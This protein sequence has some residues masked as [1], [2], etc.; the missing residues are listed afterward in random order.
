[1]ILGLSGD[2]QKDKH[3]GQFG[4]LVVTATAIVSA[5]IKNDDWHDVAIFVN[6]KNT[7]EN[8]ACSSFSTKLK[9]AYDLEYGENSLVGLRSH[10]PSP[11]RV[12]QMLPGEESKGAYVFYVKN[13]VDPIELVVKL[14]SRSIRC[15]SAQGGN[16]DGV[17]L[18]DEIKLDVHDLP[19]PKTTEY[20]A[21]QEY[22]PDSGVPNAGARGYRVPMCLYC[23]PAEYSS[24]AMAAK[25]QGVVVLM[26]TITA[27]GDV[28]D[29][30]ITKGLGYGLDEEAVD[31]VQRW[32]FRPALGP[33]G[34]PAAVR[35]AIQVSFRLR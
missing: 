2:G 31:A 9:G 28:T 8:A 1:M 10:V 3:S 21:S 32:R 4:A 35:Q 26:A 7:G 6:V 13:G 24:E 12:W 34:K 19:A 20:S 30:R 23:P 25:V 17:I 14:E 16:R 33:D 11:P 15:D 27:D 5:E 22:G 29:I 18:P